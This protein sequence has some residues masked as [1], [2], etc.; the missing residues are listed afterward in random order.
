M[1]PR[2]EG[3]VEFELPQEQRLS[4]C[5]A[6]SQLYMYTGR[7]FGNV[8]TAVAT[9]HQRYFLFPS[10]RRKLSPAPAIPPASRR[11]WGSQGEP[12]HKAFQFGACPHVAGPWARRQRGVSSSPAPRQS[13]SQL[14]KAVPPPLPPHHGP[15]A[16]AAQP[17]QLLSAPGLLLRPLCLPC[18]SVPAAHIRPPS[19]L[20]GQEEG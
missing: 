6:W 15:M 18:C 1:G 8:S 13:R 7:E 16:L 9:K 19:V 17:L 5:C 12:S 20:W 14:S 4:R 3:A 11:A 10:I 2:G